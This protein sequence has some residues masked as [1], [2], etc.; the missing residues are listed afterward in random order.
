MQINLQI[1]CRKAIKINDNG[2]CFDFIGGTL[3]YVMCV[4]S[5]EVKV[6]LVAYKLDL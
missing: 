5:E 2:Q 6:Q 4:M 3:S 1:I